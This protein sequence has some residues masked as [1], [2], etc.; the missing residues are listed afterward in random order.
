[1][2]TE[3]SVSILRKKEQVTFVLENR[4]FRKTFQETFENIFIYHA[5]WNYYLRFEQTILSSNCEFAQTIWA[6]LST[7]YCIHY[8]YAHS[9]LEVVLKPLFI[10]YYYVWWRSEKKNRNIKENL[11]S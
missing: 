11:N 7:A 5:L 8:Y 1:M 3:H 4:N 6:Q 9:K 2:V 10:I